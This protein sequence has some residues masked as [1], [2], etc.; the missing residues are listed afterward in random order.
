MNRWDALVIGSVLMLVVLFF[1]VGFGEGLK[2]ANAQ[3]TPWN[4]TK[5]VKYF[6]AN[7]TS[8]REDYSWDIEASSVVEARKK[9]FATL[10]RLYGKQW[11]TKS[12]KVNLYEK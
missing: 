7:V 5:P 1:F 11:T 6:R 9:T 2:R 12:G 8:F 10:K 4:N 3:S